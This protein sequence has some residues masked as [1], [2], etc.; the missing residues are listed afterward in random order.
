MSLR[1]GSPM[2]LSFF[3]ICFYSFGANVNV[4]D[5]I[6]NRLGTL[7]NAWKFESSDV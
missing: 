4:G 2:P 6:D 5:E 7:R 3:L 1:T